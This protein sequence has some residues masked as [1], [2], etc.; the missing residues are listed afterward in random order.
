[1]F[2]ALAF[3]LS[4]LDSSPGQSEFVVLL[5]WARHFT[6]IVPLYINGTSELNARDIPAMCNGLAFHTRGSR[7]TLSSLHV[8]EKRDKCWPNE[9]PDSKLTFLFGLF[10]TLYSQLIL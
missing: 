6:L 8:V 4:S 1:M 2:R 7:K 5:L 9:P 10:P 3:Q